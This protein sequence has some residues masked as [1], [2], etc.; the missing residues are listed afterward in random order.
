MCDTWLSINVT[1]SFAFISPHVLFSL[2]TIVGVVAVIAGV[3]AVIAGAA[4]AAA[5]G[6]GRGVAIASAAAAVARV[7]RRNEAAVRAEAKAAARAEAKAAARAEARAAAR[8]EARARVEAKVEARVEARVQKRRAEVEA[9]VLRRI[10]EAALRPQRRSAVLLAPAPS[11]TKCGHV[12]AAV[13]L[14]WLALKAEG[15]LLL[16]QGILTSC[17]AFFPCAHKSQ[18]QLCV[19]YVCLDSDSRNI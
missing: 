12:F 10:G 1:C 11:P 3:V 4:A 5:V 17:F 15:Q 16:G 13:E 19:E 6:T 9:L 18:L 2:V 7:R 14:L 8:A